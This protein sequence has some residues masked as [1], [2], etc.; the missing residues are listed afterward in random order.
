MMVHFSVS[1][2]ILEL[3]FLQLKETGHLYQGEKYFR[4]QDKNR[5]KNFL[6]LTWHWTPKQAIVAIKE[7]RALQYIELVNDCLVFKFTGV[8]KFDDV[9]Q[10]IGS[11]KL[12][13][14]HA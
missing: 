11:K 10:E 14:K 6:K 4:E 1:K 9:V 2:S 13:E 7:W 8:V 5:L 12:E 3:A